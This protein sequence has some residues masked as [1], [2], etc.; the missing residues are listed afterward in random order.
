[1]A[2]I[3]TDERRQ[4]P[5][6]PISFYEQKWIGYKEKKR[7]ENI[8]NQFWTHIA[9]IIFRTNQSD[10]SCESNVAKN[11][12][13][14]CIIEYSSNNNNNNKQKIGFMNIPVQKAPNTET[15]LQLEQNETNIDCFNVIYFVCV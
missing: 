14:N 11:E 1:M 4:H 12:Y 8:P 5:V 13:S 3:A 10:S 9:H 7:K 6:K 15:K 2:A